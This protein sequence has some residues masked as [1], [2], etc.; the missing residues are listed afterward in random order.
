VGVRANGP[1]ARGSLGRVKAWW[2]GW[3]WA[4]LG[5]LRTTK[6]RTPAR[7]NLEVRQLRVVMAAGTT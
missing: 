7:A 1:F 4:D 2:Q 5:D 3:E 6:P